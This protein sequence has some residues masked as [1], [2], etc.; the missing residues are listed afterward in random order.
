MR[1]VQ[2]GEVAPTRRSSRM[3]QRFLGAASG[4]RVYEPPHPPTYFGSVALAAHPFSTA[5]TLALQ[6]SE[7]Q[8]SFKHKFESE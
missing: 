3:A 4:A 8:C 2:Q 5:S 6:F 7:L 1:G